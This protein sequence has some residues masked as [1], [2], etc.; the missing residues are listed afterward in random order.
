MRH[1][2]TL[3]RFCSLR[4]A[5]NRADGRTDD[6]GAAAVEFALIMVPL[7][8][9]VFGIL[10]YGFLLSSRQSV[11]QAAAEAARAAAIA[12]PTADRQAIAKRAIK[13]VLGAE[14]GSAYLTCTFPAQPCGAECIGV[15]VTYAYSA[16]PTNPIFPGSDVAIPDNLSYTAVSRISS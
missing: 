10:S 2:R 7:L 12:P 3:P 9:I 15:K 6:S 1:G 16:D 13:D 11:S 5:Q 14:C 8:M 4:P